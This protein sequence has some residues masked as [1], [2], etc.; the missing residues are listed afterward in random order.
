M[1]DKLTVSEVPLEEQILPTV[2]P[3]G[4]VFGDD[5]SI[6]DTARSVSSVNKA[7]MDDRMVKNSMDFMQ[8]A[9]GVYSAADYGIPGVPQIRGDLAQIAVNGQLIPFSRNSVP[10]S[11]NNV[12]AMD[13]VKGPGSAIYGP[14]GEGAG[15]Y[16][17]FVTKQP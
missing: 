14:Q 3:I 16:V 2:R 8:F 13:I 5:R 6:I 9:P 1:L 15:G 10:L 4:S 12:E 7:W 17:N 11:F